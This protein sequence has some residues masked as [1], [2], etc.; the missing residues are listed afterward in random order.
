MKLKSVANTHSRSG[1]PG[2]RGGNSCTLMT[3]PTRW[4]FLMQAYSQ[5]QHIN[6]GTG[7]D[8]TI[9]ELARLVCEVVAFEGKIATMQASRMERPGS[10]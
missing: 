8:L 3:A 2:K 9:L 10:S 5:E 4:C 7:E 1:E 6:V